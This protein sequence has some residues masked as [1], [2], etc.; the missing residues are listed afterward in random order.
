MYLLLLY[1]YKYEYG[2]KDMSRE[3]ITIALDM[4]SCP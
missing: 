4:E 3:T 2:V 1:R